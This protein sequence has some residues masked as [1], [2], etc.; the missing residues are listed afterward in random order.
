MTHIEQYDPA[1]TTLVRAFGP[2]DV[3]QVLR[4][5]FQCPEAA[6]WASQSLRQLFSPSD[7]GW[8]VECNRSNAICAFLSARIVSDQA[9]ILNLAV[10]PACRRTGHA[11]VLLGEALSGFQRLKVSSVFLEVRESNSPAIHFYERMLFIQ[12]S[13]RPGYYRNPDEAALLMVRKF[14]D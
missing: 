11:S 7:R 1:P 13:I 12:S 8:I 3:D 6:Q 4:L 9:E 5:I 14:T 10:A 2:P